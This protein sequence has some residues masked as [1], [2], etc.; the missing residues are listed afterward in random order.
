MRK[1]FA[2]D[3]LRVQSS[4]DWRI[5][6]D[7]FL[8]G[9]GAGLFLISGALGSF[10]GLAVAVALVVAGSG[11]VLSHLGRP[12][13]MWRAA[14]GFRSAWLSRGVVV[15]S[16]L[17]LFGLL[18][19]A[20]RLF[21][22]LPWTEGSWTD[23]NG[24]GLLIW[25]IGAISATV[26]ILYPGLVLSSKPSIPFWH[27]R[28]LPLLFASY[29]V[30]GALAVVFIIASLKEVSISSVA[31]A[32]WGLLVLVVSALLTTLHIWTKQR[33][34]DV[35]VQES[36]RL[37]LRG[38]LATLFNFGVSV[39]GL[40]IPAVLLVVAS[41]AGEDLATTLNVISGVLILLGAFLIRLCVVK[42][43]VYARLL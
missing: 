34:G 13:S 27:T 3:E 7:F 23:G 14:F 40:A 32:R 1:E 21:E 9:T 12:E 38:P 16:L 2:I 36:L 28:L 43:G 22:G 24:L 6:L 19:G 5:V 20:P 10:V 26:F 15:A 41:V 29:G 8:V 31:L 37:L 17:I 25:Y 39:L 35:A 30:L 4:W 33:S 11:V 18:T 42:A